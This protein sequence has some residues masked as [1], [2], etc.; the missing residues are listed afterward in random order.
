MTAQVVF[1]KPI[2]VQD[3]RR[4]FDP[5]R[6]DR[7]FLTIRNLLQKFV[8]NRY[9]VAIGAATAPHAARQLARLRR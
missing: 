9:F 4:R 2:L 6:S 3:F 7:D 8:A 5:Y 1:D